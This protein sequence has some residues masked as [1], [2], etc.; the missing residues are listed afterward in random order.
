MDITP[1]SLYQP[2]GRPGKSEQTM[3][4]MEHIAESDRWQNFS[5]ID[6]FIFNKTL[7]KKLVSN[8]RPLAHRRPRMKPR[9]GS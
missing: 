7:Q 2:T 1:Q 8:G 6:N 3:S 4:L 9:A 5:S